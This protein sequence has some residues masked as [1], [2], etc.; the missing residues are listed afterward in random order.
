MLPI[1]KY[2][3]ITSWII[4]LVLLAAA[5]SPVFAALT[6]E[7]VE[8]VLDLLESFGVEESI[9]EDAESAL[10]GTTV[11]SGSRSTVKTQGIF[12]SSGETPSGTYKM[13]ES[14]LLGTFRILA[15]YHNLDGSTFRVDSMFSKDENFSKRRSVGLMYDCPAVIKRGSVGTCTASVRFVE[16]G[17]YYYKLENLSIERP[18]AVTYLP[19]RE[20]MFIG[21]GVL[22][23]PLF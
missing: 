3:K 23:I 16:P 19:E 4:G 8:S 20:D 13:E 1:L 11:A 21:E 14:I 5:P 17:T 9:M 22:T 6:D 2:M 15:K 18:N 12:T 7:Q 10:R